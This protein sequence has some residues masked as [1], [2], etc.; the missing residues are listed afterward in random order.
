MRGF[1]SIHIVHCY[2]TAGQ[3]M[4]NVISIDEMQDGADQVMSWYNYG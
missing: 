4:C 1:I 2:Q 3:Y